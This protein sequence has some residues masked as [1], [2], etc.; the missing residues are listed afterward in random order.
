LST[1]QAPDGRFMA[2]EYLIGGRDGGST[3]LRLVH[4]GFLGDDWE[5]EYDALQKGW[6]MYLHTLGEYLAHFDGRA[7]TPVFAAQPQDRAGGTV[8]AIFLRALG[9]DG[10]P[11]VGAT[12]SCAPEGL[13][14]FQGIVDYVDDDFLGVRSPD[15][16]YRFIHGFM[17]TVVIGHHLFSADLDSEKTE[18]AW[19]T[20][21]S[22]LFA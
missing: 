22:G 13:E 8:R 16:L 2:F 5:T 20:W 12:V 17:G 10:T 19:Q 21:L 1:P 14:P 9:L 3:V 11:A 6:P 7:V 4:S 15:A 18:T